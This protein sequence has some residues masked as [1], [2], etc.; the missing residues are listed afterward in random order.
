MREKIIIFSERRR[1]SMG[2]TKPDFN[3][4]VLNVTATLSEYFNAPNRNPT[5]P[6]LKE[7]LSRNYEKIAFILFDGMGTYPLQVNADKNGFLFKNTVA[8]LTSTFPSTTTNATTSINT[9]LLP[10]EHGWF[11]WILHFKEI[12][13]NV[14][15]FPKVDVMTG[16]KVDFTYPMPKS[17]DYWFEKASM[18]YNITTVMPPYCKGKPDSAIVIRSVQDCFEAIKSICDKG[19]KQFIYAYCPDPDMTMH[20]F[21]VDSLEAKLVIN[22]ISDGLEDLQKTTKDTLFI[23]IADH[24]QI[25]VKG[26]VE[27][28]KDE[29][30][31]D[32]LLCPAFLDARTPCFWVKPQFK[33]KFEKIF[34]K[35]YGKDFVLFKTQTL[36]DEGYFGSR[37]EFG[38]LLGDYIAIGTDTDK[39]FLPLPPDHVFKGHHTSLTREMTVPL[40][41]FNS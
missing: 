34:T 14:A 28:Y 16:E 26:E 22:Q 6:V 13:K 12:A 4:S 35:R 20:D 23:V 36:I 24:G 21:G 41:L 40:I 33:A 18:D 7:R 2:F 15:L 37:G 38:Y 25:D 19:G 8:T 10:L 32:M 17:D 30:L 29:E 27:F 9:N 31:N 11:G 39:L 5:L 1:M 3:S